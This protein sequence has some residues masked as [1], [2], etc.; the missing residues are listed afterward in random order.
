MP[1]EHFL[2]TCNSLLKSL[3]TLEDLEFILTCLK[4]N[5]NKDELNLQNVEI[6]LKIM[7][8]F[9][10]DEQQQFYCLMGDPISILE[11]LLMN[12]KLEKLGQILQGIQIDIK[13]V[14][15][16]ESIISVEKIDGLLRTYAEKSVD[17]K[18]IVQT[19]PSSTSES[20][21]MQSIDSLSLEPKIFD[22]PDKVPTKEEWIS[23]DNVRLM[24]INDERF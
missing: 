17:F 13:A 5:S 21:I 2:S 8:H 20:K 23:D 15:E 18:I 14:E 22:M 16:D 3:K 11:M 1:P 6:S 7:R 19:A 10:P 24:I 4:E 9:T 12:T